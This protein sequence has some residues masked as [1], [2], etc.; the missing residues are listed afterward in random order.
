MNDSAIAWYI[1]SIRVV[2]AACIS[3]HSV[4][5]AAMSAVSMKILPSSLLVLP[6]NPVSRAA[7]Q[8]SAARVWSSAGRYLKEVPS[9][10]KPAASRDH[11]P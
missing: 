10:V 2:T 11:L 7:A 9:H 6:S 1:R 3:A 4:R 5:T 8:N